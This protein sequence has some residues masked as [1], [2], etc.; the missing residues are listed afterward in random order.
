MSAAVPHTAWVR[1]LNSYSTGEPSRWLAAGWG[2]TREQAMD[3][4]EHW[5]AQNHD[6]EHEWVLLEDTLHPQPKPKGETP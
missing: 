4:L 3:C 6:S 1:R 2:N 5:L